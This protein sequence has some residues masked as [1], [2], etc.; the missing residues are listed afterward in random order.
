MKSLR[1]WAAYT[2]AISQVTPRDA[3]DPPHSEPHACATRRVRRFDH[4]A[5]P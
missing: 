2:A 4:P 3:N 1:Q 5:H